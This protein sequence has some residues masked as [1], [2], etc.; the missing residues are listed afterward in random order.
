MDNNIYLK[1]PAIS[2]NEAFARV[3][4]AA[5]V[6]RLDPTLE[7]MDDIKTAVSEA[8]TN[9]IVHGYENTYG[10][11]E[12]LAWVKDRELSIEIRDKGVGIED[13][14]KAMEPLYTTK[15]KEERS[16]MGFSFMEVFMDELL[17]ESKVGEG[18]TVKMKK[19]I[20]VGE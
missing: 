18:T 7:E 9:C 20:G 2:E 5:F 17:V 6:T 4:V 19:V 8:V 1:F 11:I 16:G 13:I 15:A 10:E 14:K 12:L 3:V